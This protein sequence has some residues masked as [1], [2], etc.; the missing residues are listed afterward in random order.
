MK[1]IIQGPDVLHWMRQN[2]SEFG[3]CTATALGLVED[4]KIIA[5]VAYTDFNGANINMHVVAIGK[6]WLTREYLWTCFH[7]PFE[8]LKVKRITGLVAETNMA[9]R[10]FDEHLGFKLEATLKDAH[11]TGAIRVYVMRKENCRWLNIRKAH[12]LKAA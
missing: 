11:P 6:R 5:G 10:R 9:A 2:S 4:G 7:Y 8:Y 12:E 3:D 1:W